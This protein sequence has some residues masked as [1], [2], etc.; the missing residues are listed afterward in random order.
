MDKTEI[1]FA[2]IDALRGEIET[3]ALSAR[4]VTDIFLERIEKVDPDVGG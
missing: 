2:H 1:P 3:G 4:A